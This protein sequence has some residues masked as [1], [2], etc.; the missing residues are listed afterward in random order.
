MTRR[1]SMMV[2]EDQEE[3]EQEGGGG[4]RRRRRSMHVGSALLRAAPVKRLQRAWSH[5]NCD[6]KTENQFEKMCEGGL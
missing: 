5:V 4:G 6:D 2:S 3:E 1:R